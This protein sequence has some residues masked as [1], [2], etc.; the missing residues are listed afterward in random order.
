[1]NLCGL[2]YL[3]RSGANL[4]RSVKNNLTFKKN[5]KK[6]FN[7]I[8]VGRQSFIYVQT[9]TRRW[10]KMTLKPL[11]SPHNQKK[12]MKFASYVPYPILN[13]IY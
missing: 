7:G 6:K 8:R 11:H 2:G 12:F 13:A 5:L 1:M 4:S 3:M 9:W 10:V